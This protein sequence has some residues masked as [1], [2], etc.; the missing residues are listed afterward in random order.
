MAGRKAICARD[1]SAGPGTCSYWWDSCSA[2][3]AHCFNQFVRKNGGTI[4]MA[5]A[6]EW[7]AAR[8]K[9]LQPQR[10]LDLGEAA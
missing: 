1:I 7:A 3:A 5:K 10:A 2:K 6:E 9:A 4:D 8:D